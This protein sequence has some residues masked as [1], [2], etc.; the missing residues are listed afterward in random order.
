MRKKLRD[1][2]PPVNYR[3]GRLDGKLTLPAQNQPVAPK[4]TTALSPTIRTLT[5]IHSNSPKIR[6]GFAAPYLHFAFICPIQV[7]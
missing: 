3:I 1:D 2:K 7:N 6:G 4:T 5:V